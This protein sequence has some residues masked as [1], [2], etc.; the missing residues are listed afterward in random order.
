MKGTSEP[1]KWIMVVGARP[2]FMKVPPLIRAIHG[3][4]IKKVAGF[5]RFSCIRDNITMSACPLFP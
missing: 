1:S 4:N 3:Y 5:A 2:N